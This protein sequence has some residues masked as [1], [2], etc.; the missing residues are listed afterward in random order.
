[1]P[2]STNPRAQVEAWIK[3]ETE[4][5]VA[6]DRIVLAGFSQGGAVALYAGLQRD[7]APAGIMA[8]SCYHPVP[9]MVAEAPSPDV[10]VFMGHGIDDPLVPVALAE[11]TASA[12]RDKGF[13]PEWHTYPMAHSVCAEEVRDI[14]RWLSSTIGR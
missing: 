4:L 12:L 3:H 5:G 2:T 13:S 14:A 7:E 6:P 1:M 8:L 10:T 11:R 9:S